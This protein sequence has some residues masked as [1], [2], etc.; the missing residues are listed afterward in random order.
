MWISWILYLRGILINTY[1]IVKKDCVM[2]EMFR[3]NLEQNWKK[4]F[5]LIK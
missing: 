1:E 5:E 4:K 2:K 3:N